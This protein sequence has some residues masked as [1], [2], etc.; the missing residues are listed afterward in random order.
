MKI[1]FD[2]R[3]LLLLKPDEPFEGQIVVPGSTEE[4]KKV[5]R[6][7]ERNAGL[8]T[9]ALSASDYKEL[10]RDVKSLFTIIEAA[11][12]VVRNEEGEILFIHRRGKWDLPKGKIETKDEGR[13]TKDE[14]RKTKSKWRETEAVREV[15]EETGIKK[16]KVVG[17]LKPTYHVYKQQGALMLK[18]SYWFEMT[19]PKVQKLVPQVE[20]DIRYVRWF[21]PGELDTVLENTFGSLREMIELLRS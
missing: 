9:L 5:L 7:F 6:D 1:F 17:K 10:K 19:A 20:E 15:K 8:Q 2:D 21:P 18:K 4:V 14:G 12:G 11:G 16:V 3:C 13:K